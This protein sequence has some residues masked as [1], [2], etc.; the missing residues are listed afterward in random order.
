LSSTA[1]NPNI[2]G[3]N[4]V[5]VEQAD[6]SGIRQFR[7]DKLGGIVDF[8]NFYTKQEADSKAESLSALLTGYV[9]RDVDAL[10]AEAKRLSGNADAVSSDLDS[11]KGYVHQL[12][13]QF[14]DPD[15]GTKGIVRQLSDDIAQTSADVKDVSAH[16]DALQGYVD[17]LSA[18]P[19]TAGRV[20][21]VPRLSGDVDR[22]SADSKTVSSDLDSVK[23][24]VHQLSVWNTIGSDRGIIQNLSNHIDELHRVDIT[25]IKLKYHLQDAAMVSANTVSAMFQAIDEADKRVGHVYNGALYDV[26]F[27]NAVSA[28]T[29]DGMTLF[30][31]D[32]MVIFGDADD[33]TLEFR[34]LAWHQWGS[35]DGNVYVYGGESRS[36][37]CST[38]EIEQRVLDQISSS[39]SGYVENKVSALTSAQDAIL[40]VA[41]E[42]SGLKKVQMTGSYVG[43][44]TF[45]VYVLSAS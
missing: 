41:S 13:A 33:V 18:T 12:S 39:V 3:Q 30:R 8:N 10:S 17:Y 6:Q 37:L 34:D 44:G 40:S 1:E 25:A 32:R 24:Y 31:G 45:S 5:F 14:V 43:G 7:W 22:L 21:A 36:V 29:K 26:D 35:M 16:A 9:K 38:A 15:A 19:E 11:V 23:G 4:F 28:T 27:N 42:L 20:G 2:S